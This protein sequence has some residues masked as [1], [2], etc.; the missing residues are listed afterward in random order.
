MNKNTI[1][2]VLFVILAIIVAAG[3]IYLVLS[4]VTNLLSAIVTFVSSNDM[5]TLAK[6]GLTIPAEFIKLRSDLVTLIS[7]ALYMGMPAILIVVGILMFAGGFYYHKSKFE[8][9]KTKKD[10]M[11]REM[12]HKL[13]KKLDVGKQENPA[14][15]QDV[16]AEEETPVQEPAPKPPPPSKKRK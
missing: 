6:C 12:V 2:S 14:E 4:Y 1:V 13:V 9:E 7:P 5:S 8:D 16:P 11:E 15:T 3:S 10:Q